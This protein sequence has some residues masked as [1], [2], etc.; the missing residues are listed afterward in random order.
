MGASCYNIG[1]NCAPWEAYPNSTENCTNAWSC[2]PGQSCTASNGCTGVC[3]YTS[4]SEFYSGSPVGCV[5]S[6]SS[7]TCGN[8][9]CGGNEICSSGIC[10]P[11]CGD[12]PY[13]PATQCCESNE[14]LP[15]FEIDEL[16]DCPHRTPRP[17]WTPT[18]N[19]CG[20]DGLGWLV[21]DVMYRTNFRPSCDIHDTCYGTCNSDRGACDIA[22]RDQMSAACRARHTNPSSVYRQDCLD[23]ANEFYEK[24]NEKG[25]GSF[26]DA[27]KTGCI[28]CQ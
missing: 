16:A 11:R 6:P 17:G 12:S 22:L 5:A 18:V 2:Q 4:P 27:Q 15:K 26:E 8:V 14:V 24:V 23:V 19:G 28:C 9:C 20:P 1:S 10:K 7:P 13:D 21:P 3:A 25:A